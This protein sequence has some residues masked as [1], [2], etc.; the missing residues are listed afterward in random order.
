MFLPVKALSGFGVGG[1]QAGVQHGADK[2]VLSGR[3][4]WMWMTSVLLV[5]TRVKVEMTDLLDV[6]KLESRVLPV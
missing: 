4:L 6:G 1:V 5:G 3:R 2:A